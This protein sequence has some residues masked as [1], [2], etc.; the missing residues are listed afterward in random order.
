MLE[1]YLGHLP[2]QAC[3]V[4]TSTQSV[5]RAKAHGNALLDS[6]YAFGALLSTVNTPYP[7]RLPD[8]ALG[9]RTPDSTVWIASRDAL[10]DTVEGVAIDHLQNT[11]RTPDMRC[12]YQRD[13]RCGECAL[14]VTG[15]LPQTPL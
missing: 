7:Y 1:T 2:D 15:L 3:G 14:D 11:P 10:G 5:D 9:F 12:R 13:R 4:R 6:D 8:Q